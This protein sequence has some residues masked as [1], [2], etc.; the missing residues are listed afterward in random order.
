M[1]C[2]FLGKRWCERV[3]ILDILDRPDIVDIADIVDIVDIVDIADIEDIVDVQI[4]KLLKKKV[5]S[6]PPL[7][8]SKKLVMSGHVW[9]HPWYTDIPYFI[10]G[11]WCESGNIMKYLDRPH[12]HECT[13][14][15]WKYDD[16][17]YTSVTLTPKA[18]IPTLWPSPVPVLIPPGSSATKKWGPSDS[19]TP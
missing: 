7:A 13:S 9:I 4:L 16:F 1:S 10:P 3:D 8:D 19:E 5:R 17:G 14:Y 18:L 11:F 6:N 12:P 2:K 15:T